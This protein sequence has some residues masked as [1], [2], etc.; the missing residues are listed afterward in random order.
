MIVRTRTTRTAG[1]TT[2]T[3]GHHLQHL[4]V[5]PAVIGRLPTVL[6]Q[7]YIPVLRLF[8]QLPVID[9]MK[10]LDFALQ[11]NRYLH[12]QLVRTG[13]GGAHVNLLFRGETRGI[14]EQFIVEPYA[15]P[16]PTEL[17]PSRAETRS[18]LAKMKW[19]S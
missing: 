16:P 11:N 17:S 13:T 19:L 1:A 4:L 15:A 8:E 12:R 7:T 5:L 10:T 9:V 18:R 6:E 14:V 3:D 2:H